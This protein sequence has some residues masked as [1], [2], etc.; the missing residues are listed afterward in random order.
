MGKPQ[1][2]NLPMWIEYKHELIDD[3]DVTV[4]RQPVRFLLTGVGDKWARYELAKPLSHGI[5]T[6]MKCIYKNFI[7][8]EEVFNQP[9]EIQRCSAVTLPEE[10]FMDEVA[11]EKAQE[12][13]AQDT[14]HKFGGFGVADGGFL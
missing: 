6:S 10:M 8:G 12:D 5:P 2:A 3:K 13:T 1:M 11:E 9:P 14:A 4:R 7:T